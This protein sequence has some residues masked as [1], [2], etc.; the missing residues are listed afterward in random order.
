MEAWLRA[1]FASSTFNVCPRQKLPEMSGLSVEI[2][3]K[4]GAKPF[5]A[6]TAVSY[7]LHWQADI[8][9]QLSRDNALDVI[10]RPPPEE[11]TDWCFREVY[12]SK[13]NGKPGRTVDL[14]N[15]NKW[16]KRDA[17]ATETPFHVTRRIA[18]KS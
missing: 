1:E 16:V 7:P 18:C 9:E 14:G 15:L 3:L 12:S 4:D 11:N 5:K 6:Q 17:F 8:K 10:E 2:H 13:S